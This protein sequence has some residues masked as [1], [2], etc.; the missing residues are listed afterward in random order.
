V[1]ELATQA[2]QA[3]TAAVALAEE[4]ERIGSAD[5]RDPGHR[6]SDQPAGAQRRHRGGPGEQGRGFAVVADEVRT[7]STRTH[8]ATEQIQSS[9]GQIQRTLNGWKGMMQNLQQTQSCVTLTRKGSESLHQVLAEIERVVD[10]SAQISTAAEEQQAV[11]EDISRNVNAISQHSHTN[12]N[13]MQDMDA[14]SDIL[15]TKARQLKSLGQTF[16]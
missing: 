14:S 16:G 12:S 9:I 4:S 1:T 6:G 2:E 5:G 7:L 8:K 13:K 3:F 10:L 15:L 11:V